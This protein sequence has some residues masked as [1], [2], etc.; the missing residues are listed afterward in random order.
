MRASRLL[1]ILV[2]LVVSIGLVAACTHSGKGKPSASASSTGIPTAIPTGT[3]PRVDKPNIVFVLTDDLS[4][5]LVPYM[6]HVLAME[7]AGTS[8]SNYTVTDSLCCPSRASIFSGNFP[9]DTHVF[10]NTKDHGGFQTFNARGEENS[11]FATA[12]Q[13]VG[14]R[15][16]MMGKYLNGYNPNQKL[17]GSKPYVPPGWSEWDVAGNGYPE[18]NYSLNENHKIV[19]YGHSPS[20][21]LTDVISAKG[22]SFIK[23]SAKAKKPFLLELATFA[24]HEPYVPA[25]QDAD[26]FPNLKAPRGPNYNRQPTNAPSWFKQVPVTLKGGLQSLDDKDFRLRV[27]D[28]QSVDRMIGNLEQTLAAAGVANNTILIFSS[29]NGFHLGEHGLAAGKKT[30]FD[31]DVRVPLV[32]TGPGIP[33][34]RVVPDLTENIDLAPTFAT[35]GGA[36]PSSSIDGHDF[37]ALLYGDTVSDWRNAALVEHYGGE[38]SPSDPD[39]SPPAAGNPPTYNAIRTATYTY[40]EYDNGQREYYDRTTDPYENDNIA[41]QLPASR[42]AALH[43]A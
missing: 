37:S 29:D 17:G 40:V 15:T 2:A 5:N 4:D 41:G 38:D 28:V 43:A 6:P 34:N 19:K 25:P 30:A 42:L 20:D 11:T 23:A 22:Q 35:L 31:T 32:A 10:D 27:Q 33:P 36:T 9:H 26:K 8:F 7:K 21:Y 3:T 18:F 12:L 14:Y 24:P 13:S 16:A 39:Y 1:P